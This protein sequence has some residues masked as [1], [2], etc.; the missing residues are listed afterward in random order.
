MHAFS[1][2]G[3]SALLVLFV[4]A[5]PVRPAL[6]GKPVPISPLATDLQA[7]VVEGNALNAQ[8]G[9][10]TLTADNLCAELLRAHRAATAL[11]DGIAAV[12]GGLAAPLTLDTDT[13]NALD[14]LSY[15]SPDLASQAVRLSVSLNALAAT[16][17][18]V[19]INDGLITMLQLSDDIGTMADRILEMA[20]KIL[21]M[22]DNIGLMADRILV[23]QQIQ[24]QNIA[25]TQA[26]I[27]TTQQNALTL[28]RVT[29]TA[30]FNADL[31]TLVADGNLLAV[32]MA[33]VALS[34][35]TLAS[36]LDRIAADVAL[37]AARVKALQT[38]V[39]ATT[40]TNTLYIN[41]D[42]LLALGDLSLMTTALG[43]ALQGYAIA[44]NGLAPLTTKRTL[45]DALGSMLNL[46]SDIGLMSGSILEMADQI[47]AMADNIGLEADQILLTQQ[48]QNTNIAATQGS[49]LAAQQVVIALFASYQL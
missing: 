39:D 22:A 41:R 42:S 44:V 37:Y 20:D 8:L 35:W 2:M 38:T 32:R 48:L 17:P 26:S 13:L 24:N 1:K 34:P 28:V 27:L 40:A 15:L 3:L 25:L 5:L 18:M 23:T 12:D 30:A 36:E 4:A 16:T 19:V 6:A 45:D 43:T 31:Q 46:S 21:V 14:Q 33:A 7:L 11:I 29:D 49:I 10:I 47:L 9:G